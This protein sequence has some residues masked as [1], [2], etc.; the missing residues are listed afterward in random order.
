VE[1]P[2]RGKSN[3]IDSLSGTPMSK[4]TLSTLV[5]I[6]LGWFVVLYA[7]QS[8]VDMRFAPDR[9]DTAVSWSAYETEASSASRSVYLQDPFLNNQVAWDSE[10]YLGI[11]VG[12][13]DDP[14]GG[15]ETN[16]ATGRAT[17]RNYSFFPLY[18]YLMRA[19]ALPLDIFELPPIATAALAGAILSLLGTLAGMI[20]LYDITREYFDEDGSLRA[21]FYLLIFPSAFFLAQIY[22]EGLFIGL[23]FGA[24]ALSKR[25]RWLEAS[26]MAV[27]ASW[28][29]A[30]GAVL[31]LPL[32]IA[33]FRSTPW[34]EFNRRLL[35]KTALQA[36]CVFLPIAAYLLWRFSPLGRG[37][38]ELQVFYF[39]RGFLT[40]GASL[41]SWVQGFEYAKTNGPA[42]VYFGL[43]IFTVAIAWIAS[44]SLLRRD[45]PVAWFSLGVVVLSIFSGSAQSL[46]RYML[47]APATF[48][49][50]ASLGRKPAF[51]RTW[52]IAS[53]LLMGMLATLFTFKFWVG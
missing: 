26:I 14:R 9:P 16:P 34:R 7:F 28:T 29:R 5:R 3:P 30:Y 33:W 15:R 1:A 24:L 17:E 25:G 41:A 51:D 48:I 46:E 37:W 22:T 11:A 42:T 31:A 21:V 6:W 49:A 52:T 12:G 53:L 32:A 47:A 4:K 44:L 19:L 38:A 20:A 36:V 23:A 35:V 18:P 39:G 13:Y 2:A 8:V 50:L 40:V 10:Y 45:P 27:L 43:E